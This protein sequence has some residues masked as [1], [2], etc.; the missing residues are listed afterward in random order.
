V[1]VGQRR[2][3][4]GRLVVGEQQ[5]GPRPGG[6]LRAGMRDVQQHRAEI[7]TRNED[8][9]HPPILPVGAAVALRPV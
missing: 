4:G 6:D 3:L 9:R 2:H 8:A 1:V 5:V 7:V